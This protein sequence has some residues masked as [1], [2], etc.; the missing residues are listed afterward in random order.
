MSEPKKNTEELC[1]ITLNNDAK[2]EEELIFA[3]KNDMKNSAN[4]DQTHENLKISTL[5]GFFWQKYIIS[6]LKDYSG[7]MH[8]YIEDQCKF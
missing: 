5:M 8:H 4:F 2:F 7:V 6:E 3:L 1:L